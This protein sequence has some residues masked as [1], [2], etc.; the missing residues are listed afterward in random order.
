MS[1][2]LT[3]V[4]KKACSFVIR[5]EMPTQAAKD[6]LEFMVQRK[7]GLD[8]M[9]MHGAG[10]GEAILILYCQVERDRVRHIQNSLEKINGI[11]SVELLEAKTANMVK[12]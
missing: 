11:L 2:F 12:L 7:I 3:E 6:I 5:I 4:V 9:Q 1:N 10:N 8:T